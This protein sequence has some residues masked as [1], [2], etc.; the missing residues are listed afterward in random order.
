MEVA[1][2]DRG[3]PSVCAACHRA[4]GRRYYRLATAAGAI[5]ACERCAIR[6]RPVDLNALKTALVVGTVLTLINQGDVL[7]R[8]VV[9]LGVLAK[10]ALTY[11]VPYVVSTAGALGATRLWAAAAPDEQAADRPGAA[12]CGR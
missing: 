4:G 10:I 2:T 9:S 3:M 11:V 1:E 12:G 6:H 8:G 5:V 7:L